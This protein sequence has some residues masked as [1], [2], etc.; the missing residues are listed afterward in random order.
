MITSPFVL[1]TD[2]HA[3]VIYWECFDEFTSAGSVL[4]GLGMA[5]FNASVVVRMKNVLNDYLGGKMAHSVPFYPKVSTKWWILYFLILPIFKA[6]IDIFLWLPIRAIYWHCRMIPAKYHNLRLD[7]L[8]WGHVFL[9]YA[10]C[11]DFPYIVQPVSFQYFIFHLNTTV[12]IMDDIV[13]YIKCCYRPYSRISWTLVVAFHAVFIRD[14]NLAITLPAVTVK[15]HDDVIKWKHFSALLALYAGN[16]PVTGEFPSQRP[17]TRIVDVFFDLRL[18]IRLSKQ[19]RPRWF[20]T[21]SRSLWR[22]C[23]NIVFNEMS[24]VIASYSDIPYE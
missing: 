5:N 22:Y 9:S 15:Y 12:Y 2:L 10:I 8:I 21:P 3:Q 16:S 7:I 17:V 14:A 20:E 1:F 6:Y 24:R 19:S 13:C 11:P 4:R 18:N 23:N